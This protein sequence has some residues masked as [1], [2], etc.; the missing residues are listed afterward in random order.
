MKQNAAMKSIIRV[1]NVTK[2]FAAA[3]GRDGK[4]FVLRGITMTVSE[5]EIVAVVGAS[6]A[7]KSTLLHIIG[8]LDRPS[9]GRVY[10][11]DNEVFQL[12][13]ED[14]ARFRN[15]RVGFVFQFHHLLPEFTALENVMMPA[16]IKGLKGAE[17]RERA[18]GLL[19]Q[20][21]IGGKANARPSELAG[22]EQQRIAVA[23]ALMNDPSVILADEPTGN[24]DT[25]NAAA[26]HDLMR[27]LSRDRRQT[28]IVVTH[29]ET[30]A[31]MA[32][33]V[34]RIR[35]GVIHAE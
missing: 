23:R 34:L 7:G 6:G 21:G 25:T 2:T 1:E 26:L 11:D 32:D 27:T 22:G 24:L 13:D 4:L 8:T 20:V 14:L 15:S 29:N 17:C 12:S 10:Y 3:E 30:L 9:A 19:D 28:F 31:R 16:L 33:R 18:V 35:D 5:G